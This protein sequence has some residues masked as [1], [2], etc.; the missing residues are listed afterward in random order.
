MNEENGNATIKKEK[1]LLIL[2][3]DMSIK[4][5]SL[6]LTLNVITNRCLSSIQLFSWS[7]FVLLHFFSLLFH[8]FTYT[9][10]N[11][12]RYAILTISLFH[13]IQ[14]FTLRYVLVC[15]QMFCLFKHISGFVIDVIVFHIIVHSS[16]HRLPLRCK[17]IY[18][19][20][21]WMPDTLKSYP[22][23]HDRITDLVSP[24]DIKWLIRLDPTD[25]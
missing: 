14:L 15:C 2:K 3:Q 7:S 5:L 25:K 10:Y 6:S 20:P 18:A 19:Y 9:W 11:C 21:A 4:T 17:H 23:F 13:L 24:F 22:L 12:W 1:K 8:P 16:G